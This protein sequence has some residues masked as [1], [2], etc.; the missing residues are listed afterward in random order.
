MRL[1]KNEK[2]FIFETNKYLLD[3]FKFNIKS[4]NKK[5]II[6]DQATNFWKPEIIF[7]YF[8]NAKIIL[9]TRDPRSIYY[10]MK[11]RGSYAYPGYDIKIFVKWYKYAMQKREKIIKKYKTNILDV[12]FEKFINN[13]EFELLRI[14]QF[15]Q[16]KNKIVKNFNYDFSKNNVFKAKY[17]LSKN[18]LNFIKKNLK[19]Y[20]QW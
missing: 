7:K 16:I 3:L 11:F 10:S 18:E 1:P 15:L 8:N 5:N 17:S 19:K 12:K 14:N 6:L 4:I 20:L 2:K 13:M 9:V